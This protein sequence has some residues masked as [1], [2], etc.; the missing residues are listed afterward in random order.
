MENFFDKVYDYKNLYPCHT[1]RINV[2]VLVARM[3]GK[4]HRC[5]SI[6]YYKNW[7]WLS[8]STYCTK[9]HSWFEPCWKCLRKIWDTQC[10]DGVY[11]CTLREVFT[12]ELQ[13]IMLIPTTVHVKVFLQLTVSIFL[14]VHQVNEC[15]QTGYL[16]C[17]PRNT[18]SA[19][20]Q[21]HVPQS[22]LLCQFSWNII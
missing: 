16:W 13:V 19:T 8:W 15:W 17:V 21:V 1:L 3:C 2:Y 20:W 4:L 9:V 10:T 6:H 7:C 11:V 12:L 5:M 18:V 22:T 14:P